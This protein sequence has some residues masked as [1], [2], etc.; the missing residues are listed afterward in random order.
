[1][2]A[3]LRDVGRCCERDSTLNVDCGCPTDCVF[4]TRRSPVTRSTTN[5]RF[6]DWNDTTRGCSR[7]SPYSDERLVEPYEG[8]ADRCGAATRRTSPGRRSGSGRRAP[9]GDGTGEGPT[10][11]EGTEVT[12]AGAGKR[13]RGRTGT[14][15]GTG[16]GARGRAGTTGG[17]AGTTG[18]TGPGTRGPAGTT[19]GE[20]RTGPGGTGTTGPGAGA[21]GVGRT[22]HPQTARTRTR[23]RP[24]RSIRAARPPRLAARIARPHRWGGIRA[25]H[26]AG[27]RRGLDL[28][29][30]RAA[31]ATAGHV[32][33]PR[34]RPRRRAGRTTAILDRGQ[35]PDEPPPR[36]LRPRDSR[37]PRQAKTNALM[38]YRRI[39]QGLRR[40]AE[41]DA[42]STGSTGVMQLVRNPIA[43]GP[44]AITT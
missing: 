24:A 5:L 19:G 2:P 36:R 26:A 30:H 41:A 44:D 16:P 25:A 23:H 18:G 21:G 14:T 32:H 13:G 43:P 37:P 1:M 22:G 27:D 33:R 42:C 8:A 40:R 35:H 6:P 39:A 12:G 31:A 15:G 17:R 4:C 38:F 29:L 9:T 28:A 7:R 3:T 20:G 11:R 10:G 34:R